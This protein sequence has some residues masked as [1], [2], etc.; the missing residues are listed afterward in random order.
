MVL[1]FMR[2]SFNQS[3]QNKRQRCNKNALFI[4][5]F[6]CFS[7]NNKLQYVALIPRNK[8]IPH[9]TITYKLYIYHKNNINFD[10]IFFNNIAASFSIL[11][12]AILNVSIKN[13]KKMYTYC[14]FSPVLYYL[15]NV[16]LLLKESRYIDISVLEEFI[17]FVWDKIILYLAFFFII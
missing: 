11:Y 9:K 1:P 8:T 3:L 17:F 13:I 14:H 6:S 15:N 16:F 7:F 10:G 2:E 4:S 12:Y 5:G